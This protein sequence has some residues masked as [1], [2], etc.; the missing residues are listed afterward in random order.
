MNPENH[1]TITGATGFIGTR[2]TSALTA[3][4][5]GFSNASVRPGSDLHLPP[6]NTLIHL[7]GIA[8]SLSP[9]EDLVYASNR[10]LVVQVAETARTMGYR[11]FVFLSSALVWG[12]R[13][14]VVSLK[15]PEEPDTPYARAK[16]AAEAELRKMDS[17]DF[18]VAILRPPLIYGPGVKGN[19]AKLLQAVHRWPVCP[20]GIADNR[21]SLVNVDNVCGLI[22][23]LIDKQL[24]GTFC[25]LDHPPVSSLE[26]LQQMAAWMPRHARMLAMPAAGKKVLARLAPGIA[27]RLSGSFVIED[28]SAALA[29][30]TPITSMD[31]GFDLM[32]AHYLTMKTGTHD[33]HSRT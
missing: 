13:R 26:I 31:H 7:A 23:H 1:I 32:V 10:D 3:A 20:L 17:P 22:T 33:S 5:A 27:T 12:S 25:A 6:G 9:D 8:H 24:S 14:D 21:R 15:T 2:L 28:D 16:L 19:L 4:G 11:Q 18:R 30:Y 29:R